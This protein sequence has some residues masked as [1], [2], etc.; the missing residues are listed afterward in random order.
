MSFIM[1]Q[2]SAKNIGFYCHASA[3]SKRALG[4]NVNRSIISVKSTFVDSKGNVEGEQNV[5]KERDKNR[6]A[7]KIE[8]KKGDKDSA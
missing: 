2:L 3:L 7:I 5:S 6:F 4:H 8:K 1:A